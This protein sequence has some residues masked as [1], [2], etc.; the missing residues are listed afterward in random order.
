MVYPWN[1]YGPWYDYGGRFSPLKLA[2]LVALFMPAMWVAFA[3]GFGL[4]GARPLNEAIHQ[5]GLWTI[6]LI[7]LALAITPLRQILRWSRLIILRRMIGVAA[8][9]YVLVH[10]SLYV[11]SEA[12]D[13]ERVASEIALR[14]Y[15]TIGFAAL[16]GLAALAATSTDGMVRRLGGRRWQQL[17]R[18]VYAIAVLAVIHYCF[19]SKLV[20]WGPTIMAGLLFWLLGYRLL[21]WRFGRHGQLALPWVASLS[22][23]AAILTG[24]GEAIYFDLAFHA[25]LLR[26]LMTNFSLE[27]GLRPAPIVLAIGLG[28]TIA[29]ALRILAA[30]RAGPRLPGAANRTQPQPHSAQ[31][32]STQPHNAAAPQPAAR[33]RTLSPDRLTAGA[34]DGADRAAGR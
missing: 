32:R 11:A 20:L 22:L 34:A 29:G 13:L 18:L 12:F 14:V 6:R 33:G 5:M 10:F 21:L 27:T 15:L 9:A 23:L 17:H 8:F 25:P 1:D 30:G 3:Y 16:L 26:V 2:V 19:Q 31:P 7:F 28:V 4:L 24:L